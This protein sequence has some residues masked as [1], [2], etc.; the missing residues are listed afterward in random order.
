MA[1]GDTV[2]AVMSEGEVPGRVAGGEV[3][4]RMPDNRKM[5]SPAQ[6]TTNES[7][8][9]IAVIDFGTT[10]FRQAFRVVSDRK[11]IFVETGKGA[12]PACVLLK[13]DKT[14]AALGLQ[15]VDEFYNSLDPDHQKMYYYLYDILKG[16]YT[17]R[18]L[19]GIQHLLMKPERKLMLCK[20]SQLL[21]KN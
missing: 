4:G 6:Q 13:P 5:S 16:C 8:Q 12:E 2:D 21:L 1:T 7:V 17:T 14:L 11:T 9:V 20:Y 15:A 10:S 3:A 19:L 18:S